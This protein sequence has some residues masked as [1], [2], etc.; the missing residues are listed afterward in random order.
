MNKLFLIAALLCIFAATGFTQNMGGKGGQP[1]R[2]APIRK[3]EEL[4]K[5]KMLEALNLDESVATKLISRRNQDRARIWNIEDKIDTVLRKIEFEIM[6][7][8]EKDFSKIQKFNE[9]YMKLTM[10]VE[11][12]RLSFLRSLSDI[13][14][15]DQIGKYI[16]FERK[17]RK[18]IRDLL[19]QE[20]MKKKKDK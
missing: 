17:F 10:D 11:K 7:G 20:Q 3:I 15:P 18:D 14:T 16:V 8:K 2:R 19:M 12:E 4:E 6:K 5:I 13:L 1:N 9:S